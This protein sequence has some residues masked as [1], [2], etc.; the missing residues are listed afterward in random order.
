MIRLLLLV[1]VIEVPYG[2]WNTSHPFSRRFKEEK[3]WLNLRIFFFLNLPNIPPNLE[4]TVL[5]VNMLLGSL[6]DEILNVNMLLGSLVDEILNI[7]MLLGSLVDD[8]L[9]VDMF[10]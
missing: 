4:C 8:I 7:N 2:I 5:N 3:K 6:V 10:C 1:V 9:N